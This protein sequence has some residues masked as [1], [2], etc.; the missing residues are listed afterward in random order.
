M[1][2]YY[3]PGDV[4]ITQLE[5]KSKS[6]GGVITPL[7]QLKS[8]AVYEDMTQPTM[9]AEFE[10]HDAINL[11]NDLPIVGEEQITLEI[12]TPGT[13][14]TKY[15]FDVVD[16]QGQT[17][18]DNNRMRKYI[19]RAVSSEHLLN[20]FTNIKHS[21]RGTID[22]MVN[23]ILTEYLKTTKPFSFDACKGSQRI[24]IPY[25]PPFVA[26]DM[27]RKRAVHPRYQTSAYVFFENQ[28]G[29]NF[30]SIEQLIEDGKGDIGSRIFNFSNDVQS[31]KT[32]EARSFRTILEY[33]HLTQMDTNQAI[34]SG[35]L[36]TLVRSFD[37]IKKSVS[38]LE[39]KFEEKSATFMKSDSKST[40]Q[41]SATTVQK[42][43]QKPAVTYFMPKDSSAEDTFIADTVGQRIMYTSFLNQQAVRIMVHGDTT[44][45]VG[46]SI[47]LN[48]PE[49]RGMTNR[50]VPQKFTRGRYLIK[51]LRHSIKTGSKTK[52]S[53]VID[54]VK[55][56]Y[57]V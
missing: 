46:L 8:F 57:V 10:F 11:L 29:F 49:P 41:L 18:D 55:M 3:E 35:S 31:D 28:D 26:I 25:Q 12:K 52:H 33:Q 9:Y 13:Q 19:L 40:D 51:A 16:V 36:N 30:K 23:N 37:F 24:L 48:L 54:C 53:I 21:Y 42:Y 17:V 4:N 15:T 43:G 45:K 39:V 14:P 5:I 32:S 38:N 6:S 44:L 47:E 1:T 20:S 22:G 50:A 2:T 27:L 56:G 34:N 7:D